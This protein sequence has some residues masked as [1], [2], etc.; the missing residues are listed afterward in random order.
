[1]EV[2]HLKHFSMPA[3][4]FLI[5]GGTACSS[6]TSSSSN[7]RSG[8]TF[9]APSA[10]DPCAEK[11]V[12]NQ[13]LVHWKGGEISKERAADDATFVRDFVEVYKDDIIVAEPEYRLSIPEHID[14]MI[15]AAK[16]TRADNWGV[17]KVAAE[18]IWSRGHFGAGVIVAVIDTGI[19]R[20]HPQLSNQL[21]INAGEI[22]LDKNGKDKSANGIDDDGNGYIDDW[23]GYNFVSNSGDPTD[24]NGHGTH[25]S[26]IIAAEHHDAVAQ[27]ASYVQGLAPQAK[28][29]PLKFLDKAGGG[30]L[31]DAIRAI[32]YA[33]ALGAQV[34]NASWGGEG[35]SVTLKD[36]VLGLA[37]HNILFVAASGN[38]GLDL[39]S[40]RRYPASFDFLSQITVG[41]TGLFDSMAD[42]SNFG[43]HSVHLFAPGTLVIST[44]PNAAMA[45]L[46]GTSMATPFVTGTAALIYS[47]HPGAKL[48]QVRQALLGSVLQKSEYH[49]ES[50]GRLDMTTILQNFR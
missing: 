19:D 7:S 13:Y 35:C 27:A 11:V 4:I 28:L 25:V 41:A 39:D 22:G 24:D 6:T 23:N 47:A 29:L 31:S 9:Q 44:F 10:N 42:Y 45:A 1:M 20:L 46:S 15:N 17:I 43:D 48:A 30:N 26:G 32:D 37:N 34:I 38:E 16:V 12:K 21:A 36:R 2:G 40:Q 18:K 14:S 50:L 3:V 33:V 8:N 49:N 5:F